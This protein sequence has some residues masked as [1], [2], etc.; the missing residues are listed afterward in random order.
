MS[1][2]TSNTPPPSWYPPPSKLIASN[3]EVHVWRIPHHQDLVAQFRP[4]LS[5]DELLRADRFHFARDR[6]RF[7][8]AR[9]S[10]RATL[11]AYLEKEPGELSFSYSPYGKP[12]LANGTDDQPL[13]FNLT[14]SHDLTLLAVTRQRLIGID[15]EFIRSDV[16]SGKIAERF[17]S[18]QEVS[19]LKSL[20]EAELGKAFF[21]CWTRKEAYIKAIGQGMS[22]P[23]DRFSVS[24][25]PGARAALLANAQNPAEVSRWSLREL[26]PGAGYV[27]AVAVEGDDWEMHCYEY[28]SKYSL[29]C[30]K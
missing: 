16:A 5:P 12:T 13:D 20:T 10:L 25:A 24:L 26:F 27:A 7:I 6:D 4:T 30:D 18:R 17:F 1:N 11:A 23:L 19:A 22:M 21:D 3:Q 29:P 8:V 15:I 9:G 28:A 14:H 2:S